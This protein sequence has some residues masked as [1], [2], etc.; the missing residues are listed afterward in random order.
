MS[1]RKSLAEQSAQYRDRYAEPESGLAPLC[2]DAFDF[3]M[4]VPV[5][6]ESASFIDGYLA[7]AERVGRVLVVAV[8][9]GREGADES[10]HAAN[11]DCFRELDARFALRDLGRGGWFGHGEDVSLLLVDR[12]T[13][14][15]R[16]PSRQGVGLARKVGADIAL[17]LIA[18]GR[19]RHP[20]FAMTDADAQLPADYF[21]RIAALEF[22]CSA[23][24]FPA[25]HQP[26]GAR[27]VDR[28]TALYE[29][30]LR[31]YQRGLQ[32]AE[33][34]YAFHTIGSTMVVNALCYAQVRGVP[35]RQAAED[36]Y[37]LDKLSKLR[38]LARLPGEPV[39]LRSRV[40]VRVPFGTGA[41]TA[42][43]ASGDQLELYHP[44]CFAAVGE[45]T[46]GLRCLS[47]RPDVDD[48]LAGMSPV[49]GG[50]LES[51]GARR[52]WRRISAHT[53]DRAARLHRFH[54]WFDGFHTL[55]LIHHVRDQVA[56]SLPWTDAVQRAPF[57]EHVD[58][59][60]GCL[61]NARIRLLRDEQALPRLVGP[62]LILSR[63]SR[64][65]ARQ[66]GRPTPPR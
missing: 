46:R 60:G 26:C 58:D 2:P 45:V 16:L 15:R 43:L 59:D 53:P 10:V 4:A 1:V 34:P 8:C 29:I 27:E 14:D 7:A 63:R 32:W 55:K 11:A 33:S 13:P 49:V 54:D 47:E 36:F 3:V 23:A 51:R 44:A 19:V 62:S 18:A 24:M 25:W 30:G 37:F 28:A 64:A 50:F 31:Y 57:M 48:M 22:D 5:C 9:N 40:S 21:D 38:P 41:G 35:M 39:R 66:R 65:Q 12:F 20:F 61:R 6:A 56:P 42:R 52:A 17:E